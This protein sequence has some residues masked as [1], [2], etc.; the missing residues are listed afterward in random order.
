MSDG[1]ATETSREFPGP[2][3]YVYI[4]IHTYVYI[5]LAH[6]QLA[7]DLRRVR[8]QEGAAHALLEGADGLVSRLS[9]AP[10]VFFNIL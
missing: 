9:D 5:R 10:S 2:P 7:Q 1:N 4:Y 8:L 3:K 6:G